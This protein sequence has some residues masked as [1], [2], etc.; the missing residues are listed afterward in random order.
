M[1][2]LFTVCGRAGSKGIVGKNTS[3]F[4]GIPLVY[5][6][7]AVIQLYLEKHQEDEVTLALNTDSDEL[8]RLF[9]MSGIHYS[10]F[11]REKKLAGDNIGKV[12]VVRATYY[13]ARHQHE[14]DYDAIVDFDI[15]SPLRTL[16]DLENLLTKREAS[17]AGVVFT[18][19]HSRR[20]PYFNMVAQNEDGTCSKVISSDFTARQQ[21]PR[22]F[23]MN[24]S[25]YAYS[26]EFLDS[27]MAI[28]DGT[29]EC[30]IMKDTAILDLDEPDDLELMQVIAQYLFQVDQCFSEIQEKA[31][32]IAKRL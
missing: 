31:E 16:T 6:S 18:V 9:D 19:T 10:F 22:V 13:L 27:K 17:S 29:C 11:L 26:P 28:F 20:N 30:S 32:Q 24:A 5:Y 7:L 12:D 21:A 23:D 2:Y 4:M 15:T 3:E 8:K 1:K 25:M 14:A